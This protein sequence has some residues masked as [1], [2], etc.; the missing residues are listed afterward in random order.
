[1]RDS[2]GSI[3]LVKGGSLRTCDANHAETIGLLEVV[4]M[5]K[6]GGHNGCYVE[7]DSMI[8]LGWGRGQARGSWRLH[9]FIV[10]IKSLANEISATL[11]HIPRC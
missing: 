3:I 8:A 7:G 11:L 4:K 2:H 6:A 10:E 5:L 1:M 9:H